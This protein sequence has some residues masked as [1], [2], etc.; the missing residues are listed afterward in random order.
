MKK[1]VLIFIIVVCVI[2]IGLLF[3]GVYW[4]N[5]FDGM[6]VPIVISTQYSTIPTNIEVYLDEKLVF[7]DGSL[8][9]L[10][11]FTGVHL[12]CGFHKLNVIVDQEEFSDFFIVLPIR[13]LYIEIQKDNVVNNEEN[14]DWVTIKF[15]SSP[16]VLM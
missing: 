8:Q 6:S 16:I 9:R 15:S 11:T 1:K 5:K 10:Y 7:K 2:V 14:P 12:P 4:Y 13:W 3:R